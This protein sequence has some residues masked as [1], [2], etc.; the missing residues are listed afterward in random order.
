[1]REEPPIKSLARAALSLRARLLRLLLLL[2][3]FTAALVLIAPRV[4]LYLQER[5]GQKLA[6]YGVAESW[7][8]VLKT[9]ALMAVFLLF[10]YFLWV[11]WRTLRSVFGISN[12]KGVLFWI[13]GVL[14]F[15]AGLI[16]CFCVTLPYGMKFLLSFQ[17]EEIVPTISVGHFVNF[18]GLFLLAFGLL[19]ELPLILMLASSLG[20]VDPYK[21]SRYRRHAVFLIVVLAALLTPTPD[22]FNLSL[23]AVPLYFLFE[24]GLWGSKLLVRKRG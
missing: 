10:P 23:M 18:V 5:M 15:Y 7:L 16:F 22:V 20:L 14:L 1:M 13:G 8:A 6:F 3:A 19:F 21:L 11:A 9:A 24:L 2:F 4:L 17:R 12:K